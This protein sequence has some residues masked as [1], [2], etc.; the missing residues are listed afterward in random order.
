MIKQA[1]Q[2][3]E[4]IVLLAAFLATSLC[5]ARWLAASIARITC[6]FAASVASIT[7]WFAAA[8]ASITC[9]FAA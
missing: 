6:W 3:T 4:K 8:V 5:A 9:W 7:R 1:L 2:A